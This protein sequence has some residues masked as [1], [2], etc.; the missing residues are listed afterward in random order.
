VLIP[1]GAHIMVVDG[2]RMALF[3][4]S[5]RD[6]APHLDLL[7][8]QEKPVPR[9]SAMGTDQPGRSHQNLG[10]AGGAHQG[11]DFHQLAEDAFAAAA[12]DRLADL[13]RAE[14]SGAVLVAAPRVLGIM[15]RQLGAKLRAR[16]IAEIDKDFAGR[17]ADDVAEMLVNAAP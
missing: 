9:S 13:L 2:A 7:D 3:R 6:F 1:H 11:T 8:E 12:A 17:S 16:L 5:G 15:R 4:N 14:D 10:T